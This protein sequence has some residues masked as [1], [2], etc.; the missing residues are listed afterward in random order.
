MTL[1]FPLARCRLTTR[2]GPLAAA[3]LGVLAP[4]AAVGQEV[5]AA[6]PEP[7]GLPAGLDW[8]FEFG[9]TLGAFG[10][11]TFDC[12]ISCIPLLNFPMAMRVSLLE[13]LLDRLP[14]GRP[15]VQISYGAISPIAANPDRYHIQ[16]FD[17]VVRNIPPAQLWIYRRG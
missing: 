11:Q 17:F 14:A 3:I 4:L 16:H 5:E 7:P 8:K 2:R 15:V 13:S 1:Y 10:D 9:A 6:K 12:V